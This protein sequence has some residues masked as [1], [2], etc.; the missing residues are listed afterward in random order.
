M[1]VAPEVPLEPPEVV[2]LLLVPL[3]PLDASPP[4]RM[5]AHPARPSDTASKPARSMLWC[6]CFMVNSLWWM[7]NRMRDDATCHWSERGEARLRSS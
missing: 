4:P 6:F 2:P 7:F 3:V 5:P 1:P